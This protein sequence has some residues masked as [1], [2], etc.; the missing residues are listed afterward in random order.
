MGRTR[1]VKPQEPAPPSKTRRS[2]P[3]HSARTKPT[4]P[5]SCPR[6]S[7]SPKPQKPTREGGGRA[8]VKEKENESRH[9]CNAMIQIDEKENKKSRANGTPTYASLITCPAIRSKAPSLE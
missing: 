9:R 3:C 4:T 6:Q 8:E 1:R 2:V 7:A 5:A